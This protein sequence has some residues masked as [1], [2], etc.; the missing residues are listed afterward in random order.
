MSYG[1]KASSR[2]KGKSQQVK[3]ERLLG[4]ARKETTK[5]STVNFILIN[6]KTGNN[7]AQC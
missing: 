7:V 6:A 4:E 5:R 1:E 3:K 2:K